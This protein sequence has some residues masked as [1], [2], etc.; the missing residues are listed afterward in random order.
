MVTALATDPSPDC[1]PVLTN[2]CWKLIQA[3]VC[4]KGFLQLL[5]SLLASKLMLSWLQLNSVQNDLVMTS[6]F[7]LFLRIQN[8]MSWEK[9]LSCW[10]NRTQLPRLPLMES[11]TPRSSIA[12]VKEGKQLSVWRPACPEDPS[13]ENIWCSRPPR[14]RES[15]S[16]GQGLEDTASN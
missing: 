6:L 14:G 4:D 10:R 1:C 7:F 5:H 8:W 13:P 2:A 15:V 12:K 3:N 11:L 16:V 9:P